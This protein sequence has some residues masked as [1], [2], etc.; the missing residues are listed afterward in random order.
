MTHKLNERKIFMSCVV[1]SIIMMIAMPVSLT[2]SVGGVVALGQAQREMHYRSSSD[3]FVALQRTGIIWDVRL[4]VSETHGRGDYVVFGE[5]PDAHDGPPP[6][7]YDIAEPP[8]PMP[9]YV[10]AYFKDN[11][12]VPYNVLWMDYRAYPGALKVWNLSIRWVSEDGGTTPT[13]VTMSWDSGRFSSCEYS[14]VW[15]C[16]QSGTQLANMR[17]TGSYH[18]TSQDDT[19]TQFTIRCSTSG[20]SPPV[21]PD[22]PTGTDSGKI[23]TVYTYMTR[24]TDPNGDPVYY[25]WDWGDGS[26]SSWLG[27]YQSGLPMNATHTW[28]KK[29]TYSITVKAKDSAG[30][31]SSWSDSLPVTMPCV[32]P[33][34]GGLLWDKLLDQFPHAFLFLRYL[35]RL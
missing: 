13:E 21:T 32:Y 35:L 33:R 7:S 9:P 24:A 28:T 26:Q 3:A 4:N 8:A 6:D 19:T 34:S 11:L 2:G 20:N 25:Q 16:D 29:G 1:M 22:T 31:E 17:L 5:A 12:P 10:R 15:L 23:K 30:A 14:A 18:Y 27:P